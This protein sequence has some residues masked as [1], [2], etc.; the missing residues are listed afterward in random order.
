MWDR[1]QNLDHF[2]IVIVIS[3]FCKKKKVWNINAF[4]FHS[5]PFYV[6]VNGIALAISWFWWSFHRRSELIAN[7]TSTSTNT[8]THI[9]SLLVSAMNGNGDQSLNEPYCLCLDCTRCALKEKH[10][11]TYTRIAFSWHLFIFFLCQLRIILHFIYIFLFRFF[12]CFMIFN[13]IQI[14][15]NSYDICTI[16]FFGSYFWNSRTFVLT[17]NKIH[18]TNC[19]IVAYKHKILW[20]AR[21]LEKNILS[22]KNTTSNVLIFQINKKN[23]FRRFFFSETHKYSL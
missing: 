10:K 17:P 20:S 14:Y 22:S 13:P 16:L 21:T 4:Q 3:L 19:T 11:Q 18:I 12:F 23:I 15:E 8:H 1:N 6:N 5:I 7:C 9:Y 2:I